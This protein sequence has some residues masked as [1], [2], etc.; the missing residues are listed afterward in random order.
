MASFGNAL[1]G[2]LKGLNVQRE[3]EEAKKS[4]ATQQLLAMLTA[5]PELAEADPSL[6]QDL[7]PK[8]A[9]AILGMPGVERAETERLRVAEAAE[10]EATQMR[11]KEIELAELLGQF[12]TDPDERELLAE[13]RE[14]EGAAGLARQIGEFGGYQENREAAKL[15]EVT[16]AEEKRAEEAKIAEEKR[17]GPTAWTKVELALQ[18]AQG[19]Q[20]ALDALEH[21]GREPT[22]TNQMVMP[23]VTALERGEITLS[24]VPAPVR[25]EVLAAAHAKGVAIFSDKERQQVLQMKKVLPIFD[26]IGEL[27]NRINTGEGVYAKARGSVE[28]QAARVNLNTDVALYHSLLSGFTPIIARAMSH[29]GVLTQ[30]DIDSTKEMFPKPGDSKQLRDA[31]VA[32]I[33]SLY[34]SILQVVETGITAPATGGGIGEGTPEAANDLSGKTTDELIAWLAE[35]N[36]EAVEE[37]F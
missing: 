34:T 37:G 26:K 20:L 6:T 36:Q 4:E 10:A 1:A 15:L 25:D 24:T 3:T 28:K 8:L 19:N 23:Y 18:A 27:S 16:I 2:A 17:Q 31:K 22:A 12:G 14:G 29:T 13:E 5:S 7:D 9:Q 30:P 33:K 35:Y 11:S 32:Q 21:M